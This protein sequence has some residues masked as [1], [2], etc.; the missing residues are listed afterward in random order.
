MNLDEAQ[1]ELVLLTM[2]LDIEAQKFDLLC[3]KL[4]ELKKNNT[5]PNSPEYKKLLE[6]FKQK[7]N[8]I[9]ELRAAINSIQ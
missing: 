3:N 4:D 7:N 6:E 8:K 2:K 9:T 1:S 5:P